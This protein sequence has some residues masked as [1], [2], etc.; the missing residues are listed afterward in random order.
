[1]DDAPADA[2]PLLD[3]AFLVPARSRREF[4]AAAER[5][6]K[7]VARSGAHLTLTGPW[8]PYH[9]VGAEEAQ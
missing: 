2:R 7:H 8:P 5:V 4:H 9:F 1:G 6:A 3:A